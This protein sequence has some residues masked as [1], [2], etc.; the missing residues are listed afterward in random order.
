M[1]L[2]VYT[3]IICNG[4]I[5]LLLGVFYLLYSLR[6]KTCPGFRCWQAAYF[7]LAAG[8]LALL[9]R[10]LL[11]AWPS[12]ILVNGCFIA[13]GLLRLAGSLRFLRGSALSPLAYLAIPTLVLLDSYFHLVDDNL[14]M[15][16][17]L[18]S[19]FIFPCFVLAGW[20]FLLHRQTSNRGLF[21]TC[22]LVHMTYAGL[23]LWRG[24]FLYL[25]PSLDLKEL[26]S[27]LMINDPYFMAAFLLEATLGIC[28]LLLN[29]HWLESALVASKVK[30]KE[31]LTLLETAHSELKVLRGILP[32]CA[33]CKKIR[34]ESGTWTQ[35]E[36]YIHAH[37][38]A[39]FTHGMCPDCRQEF[40][41]GMPDE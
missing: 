29:S 34:D 37:S 28:Y 39:D 18:L 26:M 36:A 2:D 5:G 7:L 30:L 40:Y 20:F 41:P 8:Y 31:S 13:V 35:V 24:I 11:P 17:L 6:Q 12:I 10:G 22:G 4:L 19:L 32:I 14:R 1:R 15:R 33:S 38:E 25:K 3:L 23:L 27:G 21:V 16:A 9:V